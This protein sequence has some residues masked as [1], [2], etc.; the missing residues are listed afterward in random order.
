MSPRRRKDA[1]VWG[2]I[3]ILIGAAFLAE[4]FI[5]IDAW[6]YLWKLWPVILI[7]WGAQK[8]IDGLR[9]KKPA[10]SDEIPASP[11]D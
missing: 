6:E 7:I 11:R 9:R 1:L 5:N 2:I 3:L 8:L 4:N 10:G